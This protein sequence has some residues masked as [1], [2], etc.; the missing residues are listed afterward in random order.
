MQFVVLSSS[1]RSTSRQDWAAITSLFNFSQQTSVY[2]PFTA[3]RHRRGSV[4][5]AK[6]LWVHLQ[7]TVPFQSEVYLNAL[8]SHAK[9]ECAAGNDP[10]SVLNPFCPPITPVLLLAFRCAD[11]T[12]LGV[13]FQIKLLYLP[14]PSPG[15]RGEGGKGGG[16]WGGGGEREEE[17]GVG[18]LRVASLPNSDE[19][20]RVVTH[21][22]RTPLCAMADAFSR[23]G[24]GWREV[25]GWGHGGE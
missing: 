2:L 18:G 4:H 15:Q 12:T 20:G 25:G 23:R 5:A 3:R 13:S 16:G 22:P 6:V 7:K 14:Q 21:G 19:S 24:W 10:I 9:D 11:R 8:I 1:R 17:W